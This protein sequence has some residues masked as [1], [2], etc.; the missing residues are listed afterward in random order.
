MWFTLFHTTL[1]KVP[2]EENL[3]WK[4]L[5]WIYTCNEPKVP[6]DPVVHKELGS[7]KGPRGPR[8]P[9]KNRDPGGPGSY[10][11]TIPVI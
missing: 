6:N 2:F 4:S 1:S 7:L 3:T 11:S 10:F 5:E 9:G 8:V